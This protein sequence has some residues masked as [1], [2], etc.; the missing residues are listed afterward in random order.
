M[1]LAIERKSLKVYP[2]PKRVIARFFFNGEERGKELIRRVLDL[3]DEQTFSILSPLLQE[4]SKRHR[5]ITRLLQKHCE[6]LDFL[7]QAMDLR[8]DDIKYYSKL[9]IGSYFTH[10]YSI[11]SAAFFNPSIIE[12][13]DQN[14]LEQGERRLIISFRAVGEGHISSIVF[15]RA[16][17]DRNNNIHVIPAGNY[18]DE[19]EVVQ[20]A[21]YKKELFLEKAIV[22][23]IDHTIVKELNTK[24]SDAFDYLTLRRIV[25]ES[26][27]NEPD[28]VKDTELER[29]LWLSDSY[30][31]I[32]FSLDTDIS[33]RVIFPISEFE[34]KGIEDARFVKF[35]EDD[36]SINYYATYTAYDGLLIMPKLLKTTNFYEF[37]I[38][39]LFGKGAQNKNLALFPRKIKGLYTMLARID[40]YN[41]YI[42][43]S[44]NINVWENPVKLQEPKYNWEFIQTGNCGSPIETED[45]W[46][47]ITHAVGPM[48]KYCLGAILL[49]LD[50]PSVVIG[51]LDEPLLIPS[52]EEREGYVPNVVYSC[53]SIINNGELIIPYG[54]SDYCSSFAIVNLKD[55]LDRLKSTN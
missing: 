41:N 55:L 19:A 25:L 42:M 37:K 50:D 12:D 51:R 34:R 45:G 2:D 20:N 6:K 8:I 10:E 27:N 54:L 26:Q 31:S 14:D 44:N 23:R 47:V 11:E 46:L 29:V 39:P 22:S 36:G 35:T 52:P 30:Y 13:P 28:P 32:S 1:R 53:G 5:N 7:F 3:S 16:L 17:I 33:D 40:G 38:G 18:I 21:T 15:R 4:Y 9:L 24:L 43:Y 48:R 49:K